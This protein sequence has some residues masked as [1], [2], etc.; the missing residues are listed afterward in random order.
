M[1]HDGQNYSSRAVLRATTFAGTGTIALCNA[2]VKWTTSAICLLDWTIS[3]RLVD[4]SCIQA[5]QASLELRF[6]MPF[7]GAPG[8]ASIVREVRN[9]K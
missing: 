1:Q 4:D 5:M 3:G 2:H 7:V 9:V 8:R 6:G